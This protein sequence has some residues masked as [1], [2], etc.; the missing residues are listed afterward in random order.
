MVRDIITI[1]EEETKAELFSARIKTDTLLRVTNTANSKKLA[2]I[3][4]HNHASGYGDVH[5][6]STDE[7]G[8]EEF[9]SYVLDVLPGLP[10]AALV[11]TDEGHFEGRM[12]NPQGRCSPI[13]FVK[14]I[15]STLDKKITTSGKKLL[16]DLAEQ[17]Q[18]Y[19][20]QVLAFGKGGQI[21]I[22]GI[23]AGVIGVGGIGSHLAQ[24]LAYLG[25]RDFVIVDPDSVEDTNLN[26]LIG[27]S[28]K[29]TGESKVDTVARMIL[30]INPN[31]NVVKLD[32]D[33]RDEKAL[34][35]LKN[36]DVIF[37]GVDND[38]PRLVLERLSYAY[39]VPYID[40]ATGID[41]ENERIVSAGGQVMIVQP[42][43]PC[44][45]G[46][47]KLLDAKEASDYLVTKPE[48]EN[49]VK[50]GYV[51]GA[52]IPNPSVVSLNGLVASLAVNQFIKYVTGIGKVTTLTCYYF[53][54]GE[55]PSVVPRHLKIKEKCIHISFIGIGDEICLERFINQQEGGKND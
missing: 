20:R 1:D 46:C 48:F 18:A 33:L 45:E 24:Q 40:S 23:R 21:A 55:E 51:K 53:L 26:R 10:Y 54:N 19:S 39:H 34:E 52:N 31:A 22:R 8:F 9:V 49:R 50:L 41:V 28:Q 7:K 2:L 47:T 43:G 3:E 12:W 38:G 11:T 32:K 4:I 29:D 17:E 27:A 15:G 35:E 37:G 44:M 6:S 16:P 5:F 25:V 36:V 30:E 42:D 13:P 14:I